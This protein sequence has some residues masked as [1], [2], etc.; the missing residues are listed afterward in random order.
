MEPHLV[1]AC[2][3]LFGFPMVTKVPENRGILA[4]GH[5]IPWILNDFGGSRWNYPANGNLNSARHP[6]RPSARLAS[7][8]EPL[9]A[10]AICCARTRPI[11]VP[12]GLVV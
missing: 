8:T 1:D 10:C 7:R 4:Y 9:W 3:Q 11:P 12:S 5:A 6:L 2:L